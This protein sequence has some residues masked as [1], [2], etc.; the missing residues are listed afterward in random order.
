LPSPACFFRRA[1]GPC[2]A[3]RGRDTAL[4]HGIDIARPLLSGKV[5]DNV[6]F[7]IAVL[8]AYACAAY[9]VALVLT[10]RRLLI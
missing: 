5:P 7:H 2:A 3:H 4:S 9:Y 10:R 8:L 6:V 1:N